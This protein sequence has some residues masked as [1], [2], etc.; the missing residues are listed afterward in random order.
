MV[1]NNSLNQWWGIWKKAVVNCV[2]V[3]S[4]YLVSSIQYVSCLCLTIHNEYV[5]F[6]ILSEYSYLY[7]MMGFTVS[8]L[9]PFILDLQSSN[10]AQNFPLDISFQA[11]KKISEIGWVGAKIQGFEDDKALIPIFLETPC[12][13]GS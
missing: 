5:I 11:K 9:F 4:T 8:W 12:S 13:L 2:L 6:F 7:N 3:I 1:R 10:T